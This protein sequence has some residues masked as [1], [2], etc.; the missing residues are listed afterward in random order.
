MRQPV[1]P[2]PIQHSLRGGSSLTFAL[3]PTAFVSGGAQQK[4][5]RP[6][7]GIASR[8]ALPTWLR[9]ACG[10][11]Y[12][13]L[14]YVDLGIFSGVRSSIDGFRSSD[15]YLERSNRLSSVCFGATSRVAPFQFRAR[16]PR[17]PDRSFWPL[18]CRFTSAAVLVSYFVGQSYEG[19]ESQGPI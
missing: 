19:D 6:P 3:L 7:V 15:V 12:A 16:R 9:A 1:L 8:T 17:K 13:L 5:C 11:A 14:P 2:I 4:S 18:L 10:I